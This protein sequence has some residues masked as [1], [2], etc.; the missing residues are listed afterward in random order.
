M[1]ESQADPFGTSWAKR[2]LEMPRRRRELTLYIDRWLPEL[3]TMVPGLVID[4]GCG[5]GDFLA[6]CRK[7]GH[8]V[9]GI[10]APNG[11]GGMG[12]PYLEECRSWQREFNVPVNATGLKFAFPRLLSEFRGTVACINARGSIE[13]AAAECMIGLPHHFHHNC[14]ELE[15]DRQAGE[16]F[17]RTFL[18]LSNDLLR[19]GGILLVAANGSRSGDDWY[20]GKVTEWGYL[21]GLQLLDAH[22]PLT[23][24]WMK[25]GHEA[26]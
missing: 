10:D 15:W 18:S 24:K 17:L 6:L 21:H 23:H 3:R 14:R 1:A 26:D 13:Q 22:R 5:P 2:K 19:P 25:P 11:A 12:D 16:N 8:D 7:M 9:L 20:D 4:V